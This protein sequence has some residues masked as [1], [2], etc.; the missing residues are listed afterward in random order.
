MRCVTEIQRDAAAL[1]P[2]RAGCQLGAPTS[3][4][5][6][7]LLVSISIKIITVRGEVKQKKCLTR[8]DYSKRLSCNAVTH[9]FSLSYVQ[10]HH[11]HTYSCTVIVLGYI[12]KVIIA[13]FLE[14]EVR[15]GGGGSRVLS[16]MYVRYRSSYGPLLYDTCT[17]VV[18][19]EKR[20]LRQWRN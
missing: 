9:D 14:R 6:P 5:R 1:V 11:H 18:Q 19:D 17:T 12:V 10:Y 16:S 15:G 7:L 4:V 3:Q 8:C 20:I 2:E 13:W